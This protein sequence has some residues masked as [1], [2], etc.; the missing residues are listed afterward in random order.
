MPSKQHTRLTFSRTCSHEGHHGGPISDEQPSSTN[1]SSGSCLPPPPCD[2]IHPSSNC[3]TRLSPTVPVS[4]IIV[5][6][7]VYRSP[8]RDRITPACPR[9]RSRCSKRQKLL[10]IHAAEKSLLVLELFGFLTAYTTLSEDQRIWVVETVFGEVDWKCCADIDEGKGDGLGYPYNLYDQNDGGPRGVCRWILELSEA[11]ITTA[12]GEL[13]SRIVEAG[14]DVEGIL[15]PPG[16]ETSVEAQES[17]DIN[18][19]WFNWTV[20]SGRAG[21]TELITYQAVPE[22]SKLPASFAYHLCYHTSSCQSLTLPELSQVPLYGRDPMNPQIV[23]ERAKY[24]RYNLEQYS[25]EGLEQA[26]LDQNKKIRAYVSACEERGKEARERCWR[27][28]GGCGSALS[29]GTRDN[30]SS[31]FNE[32]ASGVSTADLSSIRSS[33]SAITPNRTQIDDWAF[34]CTSGGANSKAR[35]LEPSAPFRISESPKQKTTD[36]GFEDQWEFG[37]V[38]TSAEE[39][40][41][42]MEHA[43]RASIRVSAEKLPPP[44]IDNA[45]DWEDSN[46]V[47]WLNSRFQGNIVYN[48]MPIAQSEPLIVMQ[49]KLDLGSGSEP[50]PPPK[51][52]KL[53][54][55]NPIE[56][57]EMTTEELN[58][59]S[60][61]LESTMGEAANKGKDMETMEESDAVANSLIDQMQP[62]RK[63]DRR[64]RNMRGVFSDLRA[65]SNDLNRTFTP[66]S[67]KEGEVVKD[68]VEEIKRP[69]TS[70]GKPA[71]PVTE[72]VSG[73]LNSA[74][75]EAREIAS[76]YPPHSD[77]RG[78]DDESIEDKPPPERLAEAFRQAELEAEDPFRPPPLKK[79]SEVPTVVLPEKPRDIA[80][81][82]RSK[83][84]SLTRR[85][86]KV[87]VVD[88]AQRAENNA[89]YH[90]A[91]AAEEAGPETQ[92]PNAEPDLR[93]FDLS[94]GAQES[95]RK[96]LEKRDREYN[97]RKSKEQSG[98]GG[99]KQPPVKS[100]IP[101]DS[102]GLPGPVVPP[103]PDISS[104]PG[105]S[106]NPSAP[107]GPG[108]RPKSPDPVVC[109]GPTAAGNPANPET[110]AAAGNPAD[111][112]TPTKSPAP[113]DP[114]TSGEPGKLTEA[115]ETGEGQNQPNR[116]RRKRKWL[117][118]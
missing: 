110:P 83:E 87:K 16:A 60:A 26:C 49:A 7:L 3:P 48:N 32:M 84:G 71:E 102:P 67:Q 64:R 35:L 88:F 58:Q 42:M 34:H 37:D 24:L 61:K 6:E 40:E 15:L 82:I 104:A 99:S 78:S 38:P 86:D 103:E 65:M 52:T 101:P 108:T 33:G 55:A 97:E 91:K 100:L 75:E 8:F 22:P 14:W 76:W 23:A 105:G 96:S 93:Y 25:A 59:E 2:A 45:V 118:C 85:S 79:K 74:T 5:P 57:V 113:V 112:I 44:S 116:P 117:C 68:T 109:G 98:E 20:A 11:H 66:K 115:P 94:H 50:P 31:L 39:E 1:T 89:A 77:Y 72:K 46:Q 41:R 53:P 19:T 73:L 81:E 90:K 27:L 47:P 63:P 36:A 92:R 54:E 10:S 51:N 9:S 95:L 56:D 80:L 28:V 69:K 111:P 13:V 107:A 70:S 114:S 4:P 30:N 29:A 18:P 106:S 17:P 12:F 43:L 21:P 62:G